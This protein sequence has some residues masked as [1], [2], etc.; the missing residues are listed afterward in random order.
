MFRNDLKNIKQL[1]H[2]SRINNYLGIL[3]RGLL[4]TKYTSTTTT[5]TQDDLSLGP[6]L[7]FSDSA[8]F[9]LGYTNKSKANNKRLLTICEIALGECKT[10]YNKETS[11]IK[12]P[13]GF[14]SVMGI[15]DN[16]N[17]NNDSKFT[18][19][20]FAIYNTNQC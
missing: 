19:N 7:Y 18:H 15:A 20:E 10:Y 11:L 16:N 6:G 9:S 3:S 17:N 2:G 12:P 4:L 14:D 8:Q 5:A 1:Y 13:D